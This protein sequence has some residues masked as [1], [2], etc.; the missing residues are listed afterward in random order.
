[1]SHWSFFA[2]ELGIDDSLI[3]CGESSAE[4]PRL[5][6][7]DIR[8]INNAPSRTVRFRRRSRSAAC[9]ADSCLDTAKQ[10]VWTPP[11]TTPPTT[12]LHGRRTANSSSQRPRT[13]DYALKNYVR[14]LDVAPSHHRTIWTQNSK[15]QQPEP[16]PR[17]KDYALKNYVRWLDVA[18]SHYLGGARTSL[19]S[20]V[21]LNAE[22]C[23]YAASH[24]AQ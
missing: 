15:Q 9:L 24:C 7:D 6:A 1:M 11:P 14:W 3:V 5:A 16:R 13:T 19:K 8:K 2:S 21:T 17:T 4:P 18:P 23:I 12:E 22:L 10:V 20:E